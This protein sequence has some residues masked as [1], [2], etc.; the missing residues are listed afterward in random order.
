MVVPRG[1]GET[2]QG[3]LGG[4]I[5]VIQQ[6]ETGREEHTVGSRGETA[7]AGE[8]GFVDAGTYTGDAQVG[9]G[10][11]AEA[12]DAGTETGNA[13]VGRGPCVDAGA[14]ERQGLGLGAEGWYDGD[15]SGYR[16]QGGGQRI[17]QGGGKKV[18]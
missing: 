1:S 13:H 18:T 9:I 7:G 15:E 4:N 10:P 3:N 12:G 2:Y 8:S 6:E 17:G 11:R 5:K 16:G 14:V